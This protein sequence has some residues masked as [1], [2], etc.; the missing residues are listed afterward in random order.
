MPGSGRTRQ[1]PGR[2]ASQ[3]CP[4]FARCSR[5]TT[6][7]RSSTFP[8]AAVAVSLRGCPGLWRR[9]G[10]SQ[11]GQVDAVGAMPV[12]PELRVQAVS[13]RAWPSRA[14]RPAARAAARRVQRHSRRAAP[15]RLGPAA[16]RAEPEHGTSDSTRSNAPCRQAGTVPSATTTPA[17]PVT[18]VAA[19]TSPARCGRTSAASTRAS[20][21]AASPASSRALPLL[22]ATAL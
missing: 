15:A 5:M 16:E 1:S 7:R 10:P 17:R 18:A 11:Q 12:R 6:A 2:A 3:R 8:N 4:G 19:R 14:Q 9:G 20:R 22:V 13:G 21:P